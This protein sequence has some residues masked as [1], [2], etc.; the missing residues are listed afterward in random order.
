MYNKKFILLLVVLLALG[1]IAM[2]GCGA[3]PEEDFEMEDPDVDDPGVDDDPFSQLDLEEN[4]LFV[5]VGA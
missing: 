2:A 4:D 1:A 5:P 3:P